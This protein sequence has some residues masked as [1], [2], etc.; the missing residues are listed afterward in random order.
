[1]SDAPFSYAPE[2]GDFDGAKA[3]IVGLIAG[4]ALLV[5]ALVLVLVGVIVYLAFFK[6]EA[7]NPTRTMGFQERDGTGER[8]AKRREHADAA[9]VAGPAA[10]AVRYNDG[11][12]AGITHAVAA[13][14]LVAAGATLSPAAQEVLSSDDFACSTRTAVGNDAWGWMAGQFGAEGM[15][16]RPTTDNDFSRILTGH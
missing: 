4:N 1:M 11:T 7:F 2:G 16:N 12:S 13:S 15:A 3:A 6:K 5:A 9:S 10:Q 8:F 14:N